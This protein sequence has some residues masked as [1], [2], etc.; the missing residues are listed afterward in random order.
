MLYF[1]I[2]CGRHQFYMRSCQYLRIL[3]GWV[4]VPQH[5]LSDP[6][7]YVLTSQEPSFKHLMVLKDEP[8]ELTHLCLPMRP[9]PLGLNIQKEG[10]EWLDSFKRWLSRCDVHIDLDLLQN[11]HTESFLDFFFYIRRMSLI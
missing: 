2:V 6:S 3:R 4:P 1:N 7:M 9:G 10:Q 5:F 11:W 8:K